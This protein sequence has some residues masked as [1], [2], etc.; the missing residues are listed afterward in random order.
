MSNSWKVAILAIFTLSGSIWIGPWLTGI[1]LSEWPAPMVWALVGAIFIALF[2]MG[3]DERRRE[4]EADTWV[5]DPRKS[6]LENWMEKRRQRFSPRR[7]VEF[8]FYGLIAFSIMVGISALS[9]ELASASGAVAFIFI[10]SLVA[11]LFGMFTEN[12]PL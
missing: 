5:D 4:R 10:M 8:F 12:V 7:G 9:G 11:G 2:V 3:R 1:E 6:R